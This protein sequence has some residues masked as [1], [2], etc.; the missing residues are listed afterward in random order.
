MENKIKISLKDIYPVINE[1]LMSGGSVEI[2]ITG[3]SMNPLL[4]MNRDTVTIKKFD[5]YDIGDIV[6]YRRDNGSFVL[7]RIIDRD[8]NGFIL[9]GDNQTIK[10]YGITNRHIIAKVVLIKRKDKIITPQS[11]KYL[12]YKKFWLNNMPIRKYI[13]FISRRFMK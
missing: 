4:K 8:D 2:P 1:K 9:C 3:T 12:L 7:H 10:E 13:L 5:S 6:F 11:R